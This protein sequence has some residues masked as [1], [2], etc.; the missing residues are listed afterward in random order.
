VLSACV[1]MPSLAAVSRAED[2]LGLPVTSA[3]VCTARSMMAALGLE[4]VAPD[5]GYF[6]SPANLA[7]GTL[8]RPAKAMAR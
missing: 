1:Q 6:L 8:A 7:E 2:R 5:A 3:A 4:C